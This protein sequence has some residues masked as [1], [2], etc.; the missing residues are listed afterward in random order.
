[1]ERYLGMQSINLDDVIIHEWQK[2]WNSSPFLAQLF[3]GWLAVFQGLQ[4][5]IVFYFSNSKIGLGDLEKNSFIK[6]TENS[7]QQEWEQCW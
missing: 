1:M 6:I 2:N 3:W 7:D 5:A 4:Q